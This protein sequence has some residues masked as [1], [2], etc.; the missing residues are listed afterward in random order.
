MQ[1]HFHVPNP[2]LKIST[3]SQFEISLRATDNITYIM[4]M[5]QQNDNG[6]SV[7]NQA[8]VK[9]PMRMANNKAKSRKCNQCDYGSSRADHLR[10]H[11]KTHSGEKPNKC[12]QCDFASSQ[13]GNLRTHLKIHR[14]KSQTNAASVIMRPLVQKF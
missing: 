2:K 7:N 9:D 6:L 8:N 3:L 13:A 14:E 10:T 11:M 1:F 4:S 5:E 12:N